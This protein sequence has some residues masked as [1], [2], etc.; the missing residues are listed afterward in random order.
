METQGTGKARVRLSFAVYEGGRLLRRDTIAQD[1]VK[2]GKDQRSHLRVD[3]ELASR[4]HAVIEVASPTEVTLID[5]GTATGTV[6]NG[7]RVNKCKL[8]VGDRIHIGSTLVVLESAELALDAALAAAS[9]FAP[10]NPLAPANPVALAN[11]FAGANPFDDR[12]A[13]GADRGAP[14]PWDLGSHAADER[15]A[16]AGYSM[17]KSGP[18]VSPDEV[19]VAHRSSIEVMVLWGSTVLHVSHLTPPRSF[20]VGEEE[21]DKVRC[22]YFVPSETLGTTRAPVVVARQGVTSLVILPRSRGYVA[23]AG[24]GRVTLEDLVSSGRARPSDEMSGAHEVELA[25]GAEARMEIEGSALVF[26]VR[27][28]NAGKRLPAGWLATTE[29]GAL[30][31]TGMSF[32]MHVGLAAVFAF[33]MPGMR[34]NDTEAIDRDDLALMQKLLN[35]QAEREQEERESQATEAKDET[36]G[37]RG[38]PAQGESGS[39]GTPTPKQ[40]DGRYMVKGPKDNPN[41]QLP[42]EV[43]LREAADTGLIG[44]LSS[45]A[46][47]D[48][49]A[50]TAI[51]GREDMGKDEQSF[52]GKM[53]GE[54]VG[55]GLGVGGLGLSG[56]GE[57]GGGPS[58]GIGLGNFGML[59]NGGGLGNGS[60]IGNGV[61]GTHGGHRVKAPRMREQDV[62]V[63]GR[64]P[65]EIIQRIVRQN[66]GRFRLCYEN[67]LRNS[68]NLQGRVT[69]RFMIDR[70]GAIA[71]TSDGGSDIPD[72]GVTQC[73]VRAFGNLSFPQPEGGS[74]TVV[75]PILFNPGE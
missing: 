63:N 11:P 65:P 10:A 30:L 20:Y 48:P 22:D 53:F 70:S 55:E 39:M 58:Q 68:P 31:Y 2:V 14:P 6:V 42:R 25:G 8:C 47:G 29:P 57:G 19:E 18:E 44:I 17:I 24:Q 7:Q 1:I 41:P 35:A 74:V 40:P 62:H 67:G 69:V 32:L 28:V 37:G 51:W 71:M 54:T 38:T 73:V 12:A 60:G 15:A 23:V 33:F 16:S 45:L 61:G 34:P 52:R 64:L 46:V 5:L 43:V 49:N 75:Y 50:P 27:A 3:D 36:E 13:L 26:R 4:M 9:P 59:G 72:T 66:F 21:G 56:V